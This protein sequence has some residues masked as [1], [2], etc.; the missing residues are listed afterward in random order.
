MFCRLLSHCPCH[1]LAVSYCYF[2]GESR[3]PHLTFQQMLSRQHLLLPAN[4]CPRPLWAPVQQQSRCG[5]QPPQISPL[6]A[7]AFS[8]TVCDG[9]CCYPGSLVNLGCQACHE[10]HSL[11]LHHIFMA[12][13][14]QLWDFR[15]PDSLAL[16][17]TRLTEIDPDHVV[18]AGVFFLTLRIK[19]SGRVS[20]PGK[21]S[22]RPHLPVGAQLIHSWH[23]TLWRSS[24]LR[25]LGFP[26]RDC[27]SSLTLPR[28][29]MG[30]PCMP[31]TT[32]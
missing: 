2:V 10:V 3:Q 9:H 31:L 29:I 28:L 21:A 6:I 24:P 5:F 26:A 30:D 18:I 17:A 16:S 19:S 8:D 1:P 32:A 11:S 15:T 27:P 14:W 25:L 4:A 13:N 23:W 20:S 22:V 12:K 7:L